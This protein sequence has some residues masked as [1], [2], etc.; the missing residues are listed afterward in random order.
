MN[1]L[2]PEPMPIVAEHLNPTASGALH[3][4]DLE[5]MFDQRRPCQK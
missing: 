3:V 4:N 1:L 5:E 2:L